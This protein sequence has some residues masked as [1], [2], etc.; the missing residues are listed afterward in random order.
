LLLLLIL[1]LLF[2]CFCC[3]SVVFIVT[4]VVTCWCYRFCITPNGNLVLS[5]SLAH[6][7]QLRPT[8]VLVWHF[9]VAWGGLVCCMVGACFSEERMVEYWCC[10]FWPWSWLLFIDCLCDCGNWRPIVISVMLVLSWFVLWLCIKVPLVV[11]VSFAHCGRS[12]V[13]L[14]VIVCSQPPWDWVG[15]GACCVYCECCLPCQ[16]DN[17]GKVIYYTPQSIVKNTCCSTF[18][19]IPSVTMHE[20]AFVLLEV[21]WFDW[22]E[23]EPASLA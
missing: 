11:V 10:G 23:M 21:L 15:G 22:A 8:I 9:R 5:I 3:Y 6:C 13:L 16:G 19:A 12:V 14:L 7:W 20:P 1:T 4:V 18:V 2:Y 17:F